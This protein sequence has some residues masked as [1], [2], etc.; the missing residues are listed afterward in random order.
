M[1]GEG[2]HDKWLSIVRNEEWKLKHGWYVT[3]QCSTKELAQDLSAEE[4]RANESLFFKNT[5]PWQS[6]IDSGSL[7]TPRLVDALGNLLSK[8]IREES[9][10]NLSSLTVVFPDFKRRFLRNSLMLTEVWIVS[11]NRFPTTRN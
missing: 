6:M 3:R 5:K 7:G 4:V 2:D 10:P 11:Q 8:M 1:I 9:L